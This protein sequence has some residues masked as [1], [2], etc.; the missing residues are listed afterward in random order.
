LKFPIYFDLFFVKEKTKC[1]LH[2]NLYNIRVPAKINRSRNKEHEYFQFELQKIKTYTKT[3]TEL[4]IVYKKEMM[5]SYKTEILIMPRLIKVRREKNQKRYKGEIKKTKRSH[6][7]RLQITF[8]L[9]L[10]MPCSGVFL[11]YCN[12]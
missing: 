5:K 9:V 3:Q 8:L 1:N 7:F 6:Y 12:I 11:F 2:E 10:V 4:E